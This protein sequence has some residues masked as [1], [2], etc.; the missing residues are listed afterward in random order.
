MTVA[1]AAG[2][3]NTAGLV[4]FDPQPHCPWMAYPI[5][6]HVGSGLVLVDGSAQAVLLFNVLRVY[7]YS[8]VMGAWGLSMT[9][10]SEESA[11]VT[12]RLPGPDRTTFTTYNATLWHNRK[13]DATY[14][15]HVYHD[16]LFTLKGLVA[17]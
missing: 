5:R 2:Y 8:A 6:R 10:I 3:N 11:R 16:V 4:T 14:K 13:D 9:D 1:G 17:L 15:D 12:V 7:E